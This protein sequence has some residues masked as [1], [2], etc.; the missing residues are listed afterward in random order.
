[1]QGAEEE[2]SRLVSRED[3]ARAV[4]AVRRRG[5]ADEEERRARVAECGQRPAPVGLG[6]KAAGSAPRRLLAPRDQP[7][8]PAA[9]DD[10]AFEP[11]KPGRL[12]RREYF[13]VRVDSARMRPFIAATRSA[14]VA[15]AASGTSAASA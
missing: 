13:P 6:A 2:V 12:Q 15:P 3:P 1:M 4:T 7:R 5:Q 8:T 14:F 10:L 9:C 11:A